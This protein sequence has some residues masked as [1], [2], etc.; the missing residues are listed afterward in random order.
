MTAQV[1]REFDVIVIGAGAVGENVAERVVQGGLT[2][3]LVEAELVGGE[4]SYWACMPS[5][6]L[7]RPG[8]ALHGAQTVPGAEE[9]VTRVLDTAAV[10][11]RRNYFTSNWQDDS[12]V[13]WVEDTGIELIRGHGW[14]TGRRRVEVAGSD[15]N[16]YALAARRAVVVATG[17]RPS[18]P[19]IDG[20]SDVDFWTTR[21][22]TSAQHIPARLGVLGGG[23]AGTE[24]AQAYARLGSSVTLVARGS[25]LGAFPAPAAELVQAGLR[26]DGVQLH[27]HTGTHSVKE[28][29]DGSL[30]LA[31]DGGR[32]VAVD[33][34]LVTTGRHPATEGIGLE[35]V[36]LNAGEGE[37]P[38]LRTDASG[39]VREAD[40]NEHEPWLYAVGDAAGK[41]MLTHQGKYEAR[42]TG[43]AIVARAEGTLSGE[44]AP[45]TRYAQTADDHAVPNVIFTDPEL[46]NVGRSLEQ[47]RRDG[48]QASSVE[49]P[50]EVAGS[51]LHSEHYK[52]WAQ[53]VVDEERKALLGATFAGPDVAELLHAATIAVVGEV[54]LDRLWH[55]VPSYPTISEVWLRLLEKYGL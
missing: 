3:V 27:L 51:A 15:G 39:L 34:L 53:L 24:L 25:L 49:L 18:I 29:D 36:G 11:K 44:P 37:P 54:P 41:V 33:K 6:A 55:A 31:L 42:A 23:V 5:K 43:D 16:S 30:T 45:W 52:G 10:L 47:A 22:A 28:N 8:T 9:A 1:E 19:P 13:K 4:C 46:A 17:S 20:L 26:A 32:S 21:E 40:G 14:I 2:A 48:Y 12:Q 38:R 35:S 7:L 50:I